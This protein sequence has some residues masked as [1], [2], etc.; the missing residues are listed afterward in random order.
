MTQ[1]KPKGLSAGSSQ[2]SSR[3]FDRLRDH[4]RELLERALARRVRIHPRISARWP[5][6][7]AS[8]PA[9][10]RAGFLSGDQV[11][12]DRHAFPC[13]DRLA[14]RGGQQ[15][16]GA[17][18]QGAGAILPGH[19]TN[20]IDNC[21][22]P[23]SGLNQAYSAS[24]TIGPQDCDVTIALDDPASPVDEYRTILRDRLPRL[25][26]G[27]VF[28]FPPGDIT[29]KILN[30]GL[31]A[32]LDVQIIGRDTEANMVYAERVVGEIR[33]IPGI[34]DAAIAQTLEQPTLLISAHRALR[35]ARR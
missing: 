16:G 34:V 26:P 17:G 10:A 22:L 30:F 27:T 31:P 9:L 24:A 13:A 11:R 6:A 21:G 5:S 33:R 32:P 7:R 19:V 14:P 1:G 2:D 25:F 15:S 8:A 35:S 3:V 23:V 28:T 29:A 12:R 4:Y 20:V 18:G